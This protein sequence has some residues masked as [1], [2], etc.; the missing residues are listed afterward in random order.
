MKS[1]KLLSFVLITLGIASSAFAADDLGVS[2]HKGGF[3]IGVDALYLRANTD[4]LAYGVLRIY[5]DNQSTYFDGYNEVIDTTYH[6]GFRAKIGYEFPGSRYDLNL[7]YS[8]FNN[9]DS[10][11]VNAP[12]PVREFGS[13]VIVSP[14]TDSDLWNKEFAGANSK[15]AFNLNVFDLDAGQHTMGNAYDLRLFAGLRYSRID[16]D[17]YTSTTPINIGDQLSATQQFNSDFKGIGP[18]IGAQ[19][20]YGL[21][22]GWGLD[23]DINMALL[24]GQLS[25][26]YQGDVLE[27]DGR[28]NK[29]T[30]YESKNCGIPVFE[31]KLGVDYTHLLSSKRNAS[32]VFEAGYQGTSYIDAINT[33]TLNNNYDGQYTSSTSV[34]SNVTFN[35]P[36]LGVKYCA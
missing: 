23:A 5:P 2:T 13:S 17:I 35:G 4:N 16:R 29:W 34:T 36:Y 25:S 10:D 26:R 15:A 30:A 1:V 14:L 3:N 12:R 19:G 9:S 20:H 11:S 28:S 24:V 32:V 31:A 22:R 6:S 8:Y 21:F 27:T 18:R 33:P 7:T